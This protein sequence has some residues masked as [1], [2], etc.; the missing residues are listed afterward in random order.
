VVLPEGFLTKQPS[1]PRNLGYLP[2]H[3]RGA[4]AQPAV[5]QVV[6]VC[7]KTAKKSSEKAEE[8]VAK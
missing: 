2:F 6:K 7:Q 4:N 5:F 8:I 1:N 3:T